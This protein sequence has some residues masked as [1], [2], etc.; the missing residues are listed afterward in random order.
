MPILMVNRQLPEAVKDAM[1]GLGRLRE[2]S[3]GTTGEFPD[4]AS[5]LVTDAMQPVSADL[6]A[7][8]PATLGL[9]ANL[10]VGTD[11]I[12]KLAAGKAGI[13]VS[14]TPVVTEDT[15]DLAMSL[16]LAACRKTT[17]Y[18]QMLRAKCWR[19]S[20][21]PEFLGTSVHGKTLGIIGF[22][23]I[24]QAVARRAR[25]FSM[26]I[27]YHGPSEKP[28]VASQV[29]AEYC[30]DL[31][32]LLG[33]ADVVTLHCPLKSDTRHLIH[34]ERLRQMKPGA[35]LINTGRGPLVDE[36]ALIEA[37]GSGHLSAAGLDVFEF[38]PEVSAGLMALDTV[39]LLPHIGSATIECRA[40]MI[41]R[42][43]ANVSAFLSAGVPIDRV[44]TASE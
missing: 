24:G 39:T 41:D 3:T 27:R 5:V 16:V 2:F 43:R 17:R 37:L 28:E 36:A 13:Q 18:E 19:E 42:L 11:N 33:S 35:I 21:R 30:D 6:I 25:A 7:R 38:E 44:G 4:T 8:L 40:A 15:A 10:G 20:E 9:I 1:S 34:A 29:G 32:A 23:A 31:A 14:N 26:K 12:D 22:G